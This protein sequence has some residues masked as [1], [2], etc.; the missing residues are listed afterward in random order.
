MIILSLAWYLALGI[1][2]V[3]I[4]V[5]LACVLIYLLLEIQDIIKELR[6]RK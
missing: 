2:A 5:F 1:F 3:T 4:A 6:R